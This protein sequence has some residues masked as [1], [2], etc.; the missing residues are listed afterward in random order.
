MTLYEMMKEWKIVSIE[1]YPDDM[2]RDCNSKAIAELRKKVG[3]DCMIL[4]FSGADNGLFG[5]GYV[6]AINEQCNVIGSITTIVS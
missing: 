4:S 6:I 1:K 3:P 2:V 5:R